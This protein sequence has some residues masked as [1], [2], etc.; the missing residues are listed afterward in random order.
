MVNIAL[1]PAKSTHHSDATLQWLDGYF[2]YILHLHFYIV[3][4]NWF[5]N[6]LDKCMSK[7]T[8]KKKPAKTKRH[9]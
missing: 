8:K 4:S 1:S 2:T 5:G 7:K 9:E 6:Q 3:W